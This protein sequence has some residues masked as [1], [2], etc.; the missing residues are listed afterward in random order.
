MGSNVWVNLARLV[1]RE[2]R[3]SPP[4][5]ELPVMWAGNAVELGEFA[6]AGGHER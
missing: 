2:K 4:S 5:R 6:A 3:A 1:E